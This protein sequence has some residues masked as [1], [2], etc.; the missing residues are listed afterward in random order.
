MTYTIYVASPLPSGQHWEMWDPVATASKLSAFPFA[1]LLRQ[2]LPGH[3]V[4]VRPSDSGWPV[5]S[6][7]IV[8]P[9]EI[10]DALS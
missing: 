8:D 2:L 9:Y 3:L 5:A 1:Q 7:R 6:A 4:A 10:A